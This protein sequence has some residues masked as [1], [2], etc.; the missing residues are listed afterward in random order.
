MTVICSDNQSHLKAISNTSDDSLLIRI[1]HRIAGQSGAAVDPGPCGRSR[2]WGSI[3]G[4]QGVCSD[5]R[6]VCSGP[7]H[8]AF[9]DSRR[10]STRRSVSSQ[11]IRRW[12]LAKMLTPLLTSGV[13]TA[14]S[15][16]SSDGPDSGP[17]VSPV[18]WETTYSRALA[19]R[20]L[21][22]CSSWTRR[23]AAW[24]SHSAL[25]MSQRHSNRPPSTTTVDRHTTVEDVAQMSAWRAKILNC[26][27]NFNF[28]VSTLL[29]KFR[30]GSNVRCF[31][32]LVLAYW[33]NMFVDILH[34]E[35][36]G[37]TL[38]TQRAIS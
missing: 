2:Q 6:C 7:S 15:F 21:L 18:W 1:A 31:V 5:H 26:G 34:I 22:D 14:S 19:D 13:V 4:S 30:H 17:N 27:G 35:F 16:K 36:S 32:F 3:C 8:Q 25:R 20:V 10:H 12:S 38:L 24:A 23:F 33:P 29:K 11:T 37:L 9:T 28:V